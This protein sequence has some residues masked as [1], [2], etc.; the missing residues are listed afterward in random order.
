MRKYPDNVMV[1]DHS[2]AQHKLTLMRQRSGEGIASR[3]KFRRL[4]R[5]VGLILCSEVTRSLERRTVG[6][7]VDID[8][9]ARSFEGERLR[10]QRVVIVPIIRG[11]LTLSEAFLELLPMA[12]VGH[13]GLFREYVDGTSQVTNFFT[14][15][16]KAPETE[17][18]L[19]DA[20][21]NTSQTIAHAV[22]ILLSKSVG[23]EP[24]RIHIVTLVA[25]KQGLEA[26]YENADT[27]FREVNIFTLAVDDELDD[28]G[29][30]FPGIG[31]VGFRLFGTGRGQQ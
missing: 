30:V 8:G 11:G 4:M 13:M 19:I 10:E 21:I 26:F 20:E 3:E 23:V 14:S 12:R 27:R 25:Y 1:I 22:S 29:I 5:E 24:K 31:N 6:F 9:T 18:F 16:P 17:F 15:I 28:E 2:L 7:S